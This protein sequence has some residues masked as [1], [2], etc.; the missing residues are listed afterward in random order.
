MLQK[1]WRENPTSMPLN[2]LLDMASINGYNAI[3]VDAGKIEVGKI[4]DIILIDTFSPVFVP[5]YN[6]EANLVYAA[7][8]SCVDTVICN[9]RVLMENRVVEGEREILENAQYQVDRLSKL[10]ND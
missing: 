9:G 8:G 4:A 6:F 1:A 10:I 5:N 2:E 3:G 7:N